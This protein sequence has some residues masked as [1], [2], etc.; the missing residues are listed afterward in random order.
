MVGVNPCFGRH[1]TQ[2]RALLGIRSA[3]ARKLRRACMLSIPLE[4]KVAT[5]A[6]W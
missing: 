4:R 3:H 6:S 1:E 2:H 5:H